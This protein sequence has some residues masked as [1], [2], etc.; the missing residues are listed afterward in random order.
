MSSKVLS[1]GFAEQQKMAFQ[2]D[3]RASER[4]RLLFTTSCDHIPLNFHT[5]DVHFM[6]LADPFDCDCPKPCY[7]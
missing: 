4:A 7:S 5:H 3:K 2:V 1:D 6:D